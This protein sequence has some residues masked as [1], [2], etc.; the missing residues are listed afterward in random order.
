MSYWRCKVFITNGLL[1]KTANQVKSFVEFQSVEIGDDLPSLDKDEL[2][3]PRK[4]E[5]DTPV[6]ESIVES[7]ITPEEIN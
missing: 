7:D 5:E 1:Q 4:I 2:D 6:T 3:M